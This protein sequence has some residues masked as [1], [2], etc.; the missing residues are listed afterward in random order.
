MA[1][2]QIHSPLISC[3]TAEMESKPCSHSTS[4]PTSLFQVG[5]RSPHRSIVGHVIV[6]GEKLHFCSWWN[7][8]ECKI[9]I[10]YYWCS[11]FVL[12][13]HI[14]TG[15]QTMW[16]T[17]MFGYRE[18]KTQRTCIIARHE[19]HLKSIV[20]ICQKNWW[21]NWIQQTFIYTSQGTLKNTENKFSSFCSRELKWKYL[22]GR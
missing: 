19:L 10:L 13:D 16:Q 6:G 22:I 11:Y 4:T 12:L 7:K 15:I 8:K 2:K 9:W 14:V 18:H 17:E 20:F 5:F 1:W 3:P 21:F